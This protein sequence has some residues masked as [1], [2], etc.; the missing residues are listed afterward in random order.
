MSAAIFQ[1]DASRYEFVKMPFAQQFAAIG[2][3][4]VDLS[5]EETTHT[6]QR[7]I[8]EPLSHIG[9]TF[10]NAFFFSGT[11]FAG[12]P[13]FVDCAD[14]GETLVGSCRD[15]SVC[16]LEGSVTEIIV[17]NHLGG[18]VSNKVSFSG[19]MF[20]RLSDGT[21]NVITSVPLIIT[22]QRAREAGYTGPYVFGTQFFSRDPLALTTRNDDPQFGDLVNW[23]LRALVV[24]E[25]LNIT[26]ATADQFP[27]TDLFGEENSQ[28]FQHAIA[29]VGN[30]GELYER[31]YED[32]VERGEAG[33]NTPHLRSEDGGLLYPNPLGNIGV[34]SVGA[35]EIQPAPVPNGTLD[36]I[37]QRQQLYCGI[38]VGRPGLADWNETMNAW[39]GIDVDYC[40]GLAS[41]VFGGG[42]VHEA[43]VLM[44]FETLE[45]GFAALANKELDVMSGAT[46][47]MMNDVRE[48]TTEQGFT[49]GSIY[50]YHNGEVDQE[51]EGTVWPLAM[52]TREDDVQWSDFVRLISLSAIHAEANG[53]T[54]QTAIDMPTLE[55]FGPLYRQAMRDVVLWIGN[56][57]DI[58]ERNMEQY[59][60]RVENRRNTL[61]SG[62]TPLFYANWKF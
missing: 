38:V 48:P 40:K 42:D 52:A 46:Y 37:N 56:S 2:N 1:G 6:M 39:S 14:R 27:T 41:A 9:F 45:E 22:E 23:V 31:W 57:A 5:T 26:Q 50:Y 49:F 19:D 18:S 54:Q 20:A 51:P 62:G 47:N 44:D 28:M 33:M 60:P 7:D 11:M 59:I 16:V 21:C 17:Q 10:S 3:G 8:R 13:E 29:A 4:T 35:N 32:K 53:I 55:L 30:Y 43:L 36:T 15:L 58:Y 12:I 61:H 24:A 25:T 34:G